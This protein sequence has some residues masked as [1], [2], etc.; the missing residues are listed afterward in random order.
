VPAEFIALLS[1]LGWGV[2]AILIR[3]GSRTASILSAALL[4]FIVT[5]I[6]LWSYLALSHSIHLIASPAAIYFVLSGLMQP[7][8]T[9]V[10]SYIGIIRLGVSRSSSLRNTD[11]LYTVMF[12]VIFLQERPG[13]LIYAGTLFTVAG[14]WIVLSGRDEKGGFRFRDTLFPLNSALLAAISQNLRKV[15][16]LILPNPF[17]AAAI[18]TL[19]SLSMLTLYLLISGKIRSCLPDRASL[20]FFGTAA[21]VSIG[22]QFFNFAALNK[23][24]VSIVVPLLGTTPL[25]SVFLSA[26]F[27]RSLESVTARVITG[28]IL[29]VAGIIFIT[30]R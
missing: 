20:P 5:A 10:L 3:Q 18:T 30:S 9:R 15:G 14:G 8:L 16:L 11:P 6:F 26:L 2:N 1:A 23:G 19:T 17:V 13:Y 25:F 21:L 24:D 22:A 12:A 29:M 27:L 7:L 4:S 28:A